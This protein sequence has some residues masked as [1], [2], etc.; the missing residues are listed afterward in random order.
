MMQ[1]RRAGRADVHG[2]AGTD[3][4]QSL[5]N[6]DLVGAVVG[7]IR[8]AALAIRTGHPFSRLQ[9]VGEGLGFN[10]LTRSIG[11]FHLPL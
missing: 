10:L 4:F 8:L 11:L 7:S 1:P 2:R 3:G 6:L 9:F 5:E